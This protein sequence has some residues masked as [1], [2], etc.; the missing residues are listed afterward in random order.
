VTL[1]TVYRQADP[2]FVDML[3]AL[4][5]GDGVETALEQLNATC[6][7][8]HRSGRDPLIL[9]P[10]KQGALGHN[11][12]GLAALRGP[13]SVFRARVEGQFGLKGDSL[14]V[15]ETI[16]LRVGA[17]VMAMKN[18]AQGRWFNGA[19]G[20]VREL[21]EKQAVVEF[22][23]SGEVHPMGPVSWERVRQTWN[24]GRNKVEREVLGTYTQMPLN[25]AWAST[26]HKAQGLSLDD[27]RI[28]IGGGAFAD[29][30]MYVALSRARSLAGLSLSKPL[31]VSD[32]RVDPII[33]SFTNEIGGI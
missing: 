5:V 13:V 11:M 32:I 6:T 23:H 33:L 30:Q 22:D 26:I 28:D 9:T 2:T 27:V 8:P 1:N 31:R 16:E 7:G 14:P 17:R 21:G 20:V 24:A 10:T 29:G 12:A 15:P 4:R 18:D 25:L 3:N 19:L